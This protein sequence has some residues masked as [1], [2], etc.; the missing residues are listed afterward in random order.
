MGFLFVCFIY[1][2]NLWYIEK[3]LAPDRLNEYLF[4]DSMSKWMDQF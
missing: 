2:L 4:N 1:L 3:S